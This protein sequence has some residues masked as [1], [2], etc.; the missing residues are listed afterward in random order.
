MELVQP[1]AS[2]LR[3]ATWRV[4]GSKSLTN[5]ALVLAALRPGKTLLRGVLHSDDTRHM[6]AALQALGVVV[7]DAGP[8]ALRVDG[9]AARFK[10]P[11]KPLFLG[12][13]GT[14]VR[15][16]CA[17][18]T[19]VP[20][21]VTLT[22]DEHMAKRPIAD[23]VSSLKQMGVEV[24]CA[25][26]CPPLTIKGGRLPGGTV[27]MDGTKSSQYFSA[28]MLSGGHAENEL[29]L[30]VQ[31]TLVSLPYVKMTM[32]L[33]EDFGGE[34]EHI[35]AENRFIIKK[36]P[37]PDS[38]SF[39]EELEFVI[40]PD[41]SAASYPFAMAAATGSSIKVPDLTSKSIQGDYQF[42]KVL[43][44]MGC[45]V[46]EG[47]DYTRISRSRQLNGI[48]VDMHHISDTVMSLAAIAPLCSGPVKIT[49][50]ANIRIKETDRLA[51]TVAELRKLGQ[52]VEHGEDWL[53]ITPKLPIAPAEI[54][55]YSD[56][57]MAMSFAILGK[58][59]AG[60]TVK[61]PKC[62]AKTYPDFFKDLELVSQN[63]TNEA[64]NDNDHHHLSKKPKTE[65]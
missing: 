52:Q 49:N 57:R 1:L 14:S 44:D 7:E 4:P 19:L 24:D 35:K 30:Q 34:V 26:G 10:A 37:Q 40:E 8:N 41:A 17:M 9:G 45:E 38:D 28:L 6:R 5:R 55:C 54:E 48:E 16:L 61:D 11:E 39:A 31:G 29:E 47:P 20:G 32:K 21:E 22:G 53:V 51:A 64:S 50:V 12:N 59:T 3:D 62:V 65:S 33:V 25:T 58:A 60:I 2:P 46:E 23:L 27:S 42:V 43:H 56:H 15:F 18:C 36:M 13:S 63:G